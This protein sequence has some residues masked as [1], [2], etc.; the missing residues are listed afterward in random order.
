MTI[1][2]RCHIRQKLKEVPES[3]ISLTI[4]NGRSA[5][6]LSE[7]SKEL[8]KGGP[9]RHGKQPLKWRE[10]SRNKK[11]VESGKIENRLLNGIW[12]AKWDRH[13]TWVQNYFLECRAR[14][15]TCIYILG[16]S[17]ACAIPHNVLATLSNIWCIELLK[18][19]RNRVF[20]S[21]ET[22]TSEA[23]AAESCNPIK[24]LSPK[25]KQR[26]GI[27]LKEWKEV[28]FITF[29]SWLNLCWPILQRKGGARMKLKNP[30]SENI[31]MDGDNS[32]YSLLTQFWNHFNDI[33]AIW[34]NWSLVVLQFVT[35]VSL[36]L[37]HNALVRLHLVC[38]RKHGMHFRSTACILRNFSLR[39]H[40][41]FQNC[42]IILASFRPWS[43]KTTLNITSMNKWIRC[44]LPLVFQR[45]Q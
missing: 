20:Q 2:T 16:Q 34:F 28:K 44:V 39:L 45:K 21:I 37:H 31:I 5:L 9:Q 26:N 6:T 27:S 25:W 33:L 3:V 4:V 15:I 13:K 10:I 17:P 29:S 32:F 18:P 41:T 40:E 22:W 24:I 38:Q 43:F 12:G 42:A 14:T 1:H 35:A 8:D 19:Q 11:E 23:R 7:P 30:Y 36:R